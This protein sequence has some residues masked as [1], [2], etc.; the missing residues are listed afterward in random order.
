MGL[1]GRT[2]ISIFLGYADEENCVFDHVW[3]IN[4]LDLR[5]HGIGRSIKLIDF[6]LNCEQ[7]VCYTNTG[8]IVTWDLKRLKLSQ[9]IYICKQKT[10]TPITHIK[11]VAN[12]NKI[13]TYS[14]PQN[15]LMIIDAE[16]IKSNPKDP[17]NA[18]T[19]DEFIIRITPS[20]EGFGRVVNFQV[21][22]TDQFLVCAFERNKLAVYGMK[23]G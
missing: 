17:E 16:G 5:K 3:T 8:H 22:N 13:V 20:A 21:D 14:E 23:S 12:N 19:I 18:L 15:K 7:F 2:K 1:I 6:S 11:S 10:E 9:K 4:F